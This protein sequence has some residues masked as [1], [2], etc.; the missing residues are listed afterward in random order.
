MKEKSDQNPDRNSCGSLDRD[1]RIRI[2]I[3]IRI[4]GSA[5]NHCGSTTLLLTKV[6]FSVSANLSFNSK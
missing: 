4:G 6:F 1:L 5:L 3:W 2:K